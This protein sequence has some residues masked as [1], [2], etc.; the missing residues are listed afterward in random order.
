MLEIIKITNYW[1]WVERH[2]HHY[3]MKMQVPYRNYVR[4]TASETLPVSKSFLLLLLVFNSLIDLRLS[5]FDSLFCIERAWY[6]IVQ[7]TRIPY[8]YSKSNDCF[9]AAG[10]TKL[11]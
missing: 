5:G 3:W 1:I 4:Q 7:S 11:V 10:V 6:K 8:P 9:T 2:Y